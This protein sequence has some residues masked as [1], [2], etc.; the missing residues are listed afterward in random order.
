MSYITS[1]AARKPLEITTPSTT[2]WQAWWAAESER[3]GTNWQSIAALHFQ[4]CERLRP[5]M[6]SPTCG[7][8]PCRNPQ[9]CAL[10]RKADA[11]RASQTE[12]ADVLRYRHLLSR[13]DSVSFEAIWRELNTIKCRVAASTVEAL[14][15]GLGERGVKALSKSAVRRRLSE[16][17]EQQIHEVCAR[18]QRLK[19]EIARAWAPDEVI[20][21]L[22]AWNICHG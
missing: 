22:D 10:C 12:S 14:M 3:I 5:A 11:A 15:L 9:F 8:D 6:T 20:V 17:S 7:S 13:P 19:P 2:N 16:L 4:I 1:T 21:L 18:L